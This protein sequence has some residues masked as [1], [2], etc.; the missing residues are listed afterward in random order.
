MS[1]TNDTQIDYKTA[2][3]IAKAKRPF[4]KKKRYWLLA[5]VA[6]VIIAMMAGE[7]RWRF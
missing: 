3:A 6:I 2:K 5:F 1:D 7:Q 4:F